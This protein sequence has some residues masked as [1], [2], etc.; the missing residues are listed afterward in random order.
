MLFQQLTVKYGIRYKLV[1]LLCLMEDLTQDA[2][3]AKP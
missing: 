3:V 2:A 1:L